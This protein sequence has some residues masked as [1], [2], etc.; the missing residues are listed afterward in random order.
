MIN[1]KGLELPQWGNLRRTRPFSDHYGFDRGTPIDR[2]YVM[3]FMERHGRHITGDVLEIQGTAYTQACGSNVRRSE[4][5]DIDPQHGTTYVGDLAHSASVLAS[6]AYDCFLLPNTLNHLKE[7]DACLRNALRVVKPGGVVLATAPTL[8]PLTPDFSEYR[9][10]T[11]AGLQ[12][13]AHRVWPGCEI[14]VESY[15]NVLSATAALMGL[16]HEELSAEELDVND[17]RYPVLLTL[18]CRKAG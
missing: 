11:A 18:F 6:D 12:E 7:L 3:K 4:S 1:T 13:I 9:R 10:F 2:Y 15:G 17:A 16:A 8:T 5:L 14:N